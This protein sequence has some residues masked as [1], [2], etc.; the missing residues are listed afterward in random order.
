VRWLYLDTETALEI[1]AE[2]LRTVAGRQRLVETIYSDWQDKDGLLIARRQETTTE[3]DTQ[4]HFLTVDS[5][6]INPVI[7]DSRFVMPTT[8]ANRAITVRRKS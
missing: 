3:G 5:V 2:A 4:S 1:K 7:N 8:T 6:T